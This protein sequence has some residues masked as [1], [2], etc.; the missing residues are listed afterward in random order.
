MLASL[1]CAARK[2]SSRASAEHL[3][4]ICSLTSLG[5][6]LVGLQASSENSLDPPHCTSRVRAAYQGRRSFSSG[7]TADTHAPPSE[8]LHRQG[9][10]SR[11]QWQA[12]NGRAS[13]QEEQSVA[14]DMQHVMPASALHNSAATAA[15]AAVAAAPVQASAAEELS[16]TSPVPPGRV[17]NTPPPPWTPTHQLKKRNFL[18]RRM[19]HL[20]QVRCFRS[21]WSVRYL[22]EGSR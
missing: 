9:Q 8:P 10:R 12:R 1:R 2:I 15:A 3:H 6:L 22:L 20:I 14:G 5:D 11:A 13:L 21:F 18:P 7:Q 4:A 19:G 16:V 17:Q